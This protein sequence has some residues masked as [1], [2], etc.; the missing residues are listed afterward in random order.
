V[1]HSAL[2]FDGQNNSLRYGNKNLY[3]L[4]SGV[5]RRLLRDDTR[6][7]AFMS[8][9]KL[10]EIVG[11]KQFQGYVDRITVE[12]RTLYEQLCNDNKMGNGTSTGE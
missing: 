1:N 2:V 3:I 9:Q 7:A 8:M 12:Q 6:H 5:A 4:V 11:P 10:A